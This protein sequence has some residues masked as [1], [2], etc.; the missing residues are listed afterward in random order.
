MTDDIKHSFLKISNINS[1][2]TLL[3]RHLNIRFYLGTYLMN[4][5]KFVAVN[6]KVF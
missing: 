6:I 5:L 2:Y 4:K 1:L 3:Y